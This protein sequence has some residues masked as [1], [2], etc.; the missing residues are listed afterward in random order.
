[1]SGILGNNHGSPE[2]NFKQDKKG[3]KRRDEINRTNSTNDTNNTN[4]T[5][6]TRDKNGIIGTTSTT[7]TTS[8]NGINFL[9]KV[10]V[11]NLASGGLEF[12][13]PFPPKASL[14]T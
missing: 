13:Y 10:Y 11:C 8:T 12:K 4:D 2:R 6:D 9:H 3:A 5:I 1:M 7:S 14:I